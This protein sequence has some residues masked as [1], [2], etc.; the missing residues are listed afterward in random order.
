MR[1]LALAALMILT[2]CA[3]PTRTARGPAPTPEGGASASAAPETAAAPVVDKSAYLPLGKA[4]PS[5]CKA[6]WKKLRAE[7]EVASAGC[8]SDQD[9]EEFMTCDAVTKPN[10]P[11]LWKL[12]DEAKAACQGL[13]GDEIT[14]AFTP[15]QCY[16]GRCQRR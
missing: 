4:D 12:R 16:Q 9:C 11:R 2:A 1:R 6:S 5:A 15:P 10:A 8:T 3:A 7:L 14:C 13:P